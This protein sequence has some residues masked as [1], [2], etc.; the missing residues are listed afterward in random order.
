MAI[1]IPPGL[2]ISK[3]FTCENCVRLYRGYGK[4]QGTEQG[5]EGF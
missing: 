2:V 4:V 1:S 5:K 3:L